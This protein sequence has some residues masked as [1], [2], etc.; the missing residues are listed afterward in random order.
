ML[1]EARRET[2]HALTLIRIAK[3]RVRENGNLSAGELAAL[4][5]GIAKTVIRSTPEL[6]ELAQSIYTPEQM[7]KI[8][9]RERDPEEIAQA[10]EFW[11]AMSADIERIVPNGD[12]LSEDGLSVARRLV[13]F[14][15]GMTRGDAALWNSSSLFWKRAVADPRMFDQLP[16]KQAHWDFVGKAMEELQRRGEIT[17]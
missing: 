7:A 15:R 16:F 11:R 10:S 1:S 13:A 4:V 12:P 17:P 3:V 2:D 9:A 14:F 8:L 5:A 6:D